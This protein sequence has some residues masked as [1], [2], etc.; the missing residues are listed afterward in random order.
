V[1]KMAKTK[2]FTTPLKN[3]RLLSDQ[4]ELSISEGRPLYAKLDKIEVLI[5]NLKEEVKV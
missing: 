3:L 4:V 5:S 2:V 1:V